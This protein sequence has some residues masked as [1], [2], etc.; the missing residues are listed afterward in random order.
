M[1]RMGVGDKGEGERRRKQRQRRWPTDERRF[2]SVRTAPAGLKQH[3]TVITASPTESARPPWYMERTA[4][5]A[6]AGT[7]QWKIELG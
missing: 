7:L 3:N 6:Q 1:V 4:S 2:S 5:M